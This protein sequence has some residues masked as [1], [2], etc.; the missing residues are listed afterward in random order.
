MSLFDDLYYGNINISER[1]VAG[2]VADG[3]DEKA[4]LEAAVAAENALSEQLPD[5]LK[6]M[7]TAL[8]SAHDLLLDATSRS[9]FEIGFKYGMRFA[10]AGLSDDKI[11]VDNSEDE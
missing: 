6:P 4:A 3:S 2:E 10:V 9:V 5:N 11:G 7:L 8:V 1:D